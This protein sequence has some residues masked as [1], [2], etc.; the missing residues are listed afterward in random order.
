METT[1]WKKI[2]L[3]LVLGLLMALLVAC[4][5]KTEEPKSIEK[6]TE[7]EEVVED[8]PEDEEEE[9]SLQT[10]KVAID[11]SGEPEEILAKY[12]EEGMSAFKLNFPDTL[13]MNYALKSIGKEPTEIKGTTM[14]GEEVSLSELKG[15]DVIISFSKTTCSICK[16]MIPVMEKVAKENT[17]VV[18]LNVFPVDVNKDIEAFYKTKESTIPTHTLSLEDNKHLKD[19]AIK[20]YMIEQVPTYVFVDKTGTISYTYI[21]NK[22]EVMF[23]DMLTTAFGEVKLHDKVRTV[24]VRVDAEGNEIVND[25]LVEEEKIDGD[26]VDHTE[27]SPEKEEK[28]VVVEKKAET[29]QVEKK[30]EKESNK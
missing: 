12:T 7:T 3:V 23:Q 10:R 1:K 6:E 22:D 19:V 13:T 4:G 14:A 21:G 18:F 20:D 2:S 25:K 17:E 15:K 11:Y 27:S 9:V 8:A 29:K 24:V 30:S 28:E 5:N 26:G 16:D